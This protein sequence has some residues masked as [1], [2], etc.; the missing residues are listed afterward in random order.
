MRALAVL[1]GRPYP[2]CA[3]PDRGRDTLPPERAVSAISPRHLPQTGQICQ[4]LRSPRTWPASLT[5]PELEATRPLIPRFSA[6]TCQQASYST[7]FQVC[8]LLVE[9]SGWLILKTRV[10]YIRNAPASSIDAAPCCLRMNV[11]SQ[12]SWKY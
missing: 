12:I 3:R 8:S 6:G 2:L 10:S 4:L 7:I 1:A 5:L 9:P 11:H